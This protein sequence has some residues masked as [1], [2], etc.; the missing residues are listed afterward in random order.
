MSP[1]FYT[2]VRCTI[3]SALYIFDC[4]MYIIQCTLYNVHKSKTI[5]SRAVVG[6]RVT[7]SSDEAE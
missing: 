6:T 3:C 5:T 4:F 7:S 1:K 2:H